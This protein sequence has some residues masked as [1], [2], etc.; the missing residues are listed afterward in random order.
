MSKQQE[1]R[2][3][4]TNQIIAA[5]E[6]GSLPWRRPWS[7]SANAG[8]PCNS[9]TR[10]LYRGVNPFVLQLSADRQGF[11]SRFWATFR[12]WQSIGCSVMKGQKGTQITFSTPIT[13]TTTDKK[14]EEQEEKF[15]I[16]RPFTVFNAEQTSGAERFHVG[17]EPVS[18]EEL[19][20][21]FDEAQRVVEATEARIVHG[22]DRA[23]Y[24]PETDTI[25][26]P[27]RSQ[28][29]G[30]DYFDTLFHELSHWTE[31]P[32]RLNWDRS[33]AANTYAAGE[34]RAELAAC[35]L[36][37]QLGLP[38]EHLVSNH[39]AYLQH[40]LEQMRE[41]PSFIFRISAQASKAADFIMSFSCKPEP[42]EEEAVA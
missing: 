17:D 24:R 1:L 7:I 21:R 10:R 37:N 29:K 18:I 12:Q 42:V 25:H 40:W 41:N 33:K 22:G 38:S 3:S 32:S 2:E 11:R 34:L 13:K 35:Y 20:H 36:S 5:I 30:A 15:W 31:Q 4:I 9:I 39:A 14:G 27:N 6:G 28:F 16:L 19:D 23:F 8:A 26:M